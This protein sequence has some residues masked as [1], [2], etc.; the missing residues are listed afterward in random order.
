MVLCLFGESK[1]HSDKNLFCL[2]LYSAQEQGSGKPGDQNHQ[3]KND[4]F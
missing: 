4:L 3:V 1:S 2:S